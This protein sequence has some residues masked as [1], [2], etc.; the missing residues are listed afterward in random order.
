M[1]IK[2]NGRDH[3]FDE[4]LNLS[5]LIE[6]IDVKQSLFVIELNK[7]IIHKDKYDNVYLNDNDAVEIVSFVG[8]G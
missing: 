3:T 7:K 4:S 8:G 2:V 6:K 5:Q 1:N